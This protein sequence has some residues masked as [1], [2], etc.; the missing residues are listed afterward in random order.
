M[1]ESYQQTLAQTREALLRELDSLSQGLNL[2]LDTSSSSRDTRL[3]LVE[4]IRTTI[5]ALHALSGLPT[6]EEPTVKKEREVARR[7]NVS[8]TQFPTLEGF[9]LDLGAPYATNLLEAQVNAVEATVALSLPGSRVDVAKAT[10][11]LRA[12]RD[13]GV[14]IHVALGGESTLSKKK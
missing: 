2:L 1:N 9:I 14:P 5:D 8:L 6:M 10:D 12:L 7:R 13:N 3:L 4:A 11:F